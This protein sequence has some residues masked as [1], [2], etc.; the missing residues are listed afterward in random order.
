MASGLSSGTRFPPD[1]PNP[2]DLVA[3]DEALATVLDRITPLAPRP[4]PLA[5]ALGCV[6]AEDVAAADTVLSF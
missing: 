2:P 1:R 5:E 3:F 6:L 4:L